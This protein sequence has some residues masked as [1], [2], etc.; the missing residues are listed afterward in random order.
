MFTGIVNLPRGRIKV[1]VCDMMVLIAS[2]HIALSWP[3]SLENNHSKELVCGCFIDFR[4]SVSNR[5]PSPVVMHYSHIQKQLIHLSSFWEN[6]PALVISYIRNMSSSLWVVII[7][8]VFIHNC[9]PP[10]H[11]PSHNLDIQPL[12]TSPQ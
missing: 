1:P 3:L 4:Y 2:F 7:G 9:T 5:I 11:I 8:G 6:F 10:C 12:V